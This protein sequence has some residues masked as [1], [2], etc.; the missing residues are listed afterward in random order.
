MTATH[1]DLKVLIYDSY[2][3][4]L[5]Q[6]TIATPTVLAPRIT[7]LV[8]RLFLAKYTGLSTGAFSS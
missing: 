5:E 3:K 7:K 6:P 1:F 2:K 8:I 4:Y